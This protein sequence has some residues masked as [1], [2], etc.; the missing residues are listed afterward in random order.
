MGKKAGAVKAKKSGKVRPEKIEAEIK[1]KESEEKAG[2]IEEVVQKRG[3]TTFL[4]LIKPRVGPS[5]SSGEKPKDKK[6]VG[7]KSKQPALK[8]ERYP[9]AKDGTR[10]AK[11]QIFRES[12][13][14][15][16]SVWSELKKVHW[17]GRTEIVVYTSVVLGSVIFV[18]LLIWLADSIL[19]RIL[20]LIL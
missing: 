18:A 17:P 19:S 8:E 3:V 4:R 12:F 2:G 9:R 7:G 15:L 6:K 16:Q 5:R 13:R 20:E 10:G 11:T 14:F 1:K